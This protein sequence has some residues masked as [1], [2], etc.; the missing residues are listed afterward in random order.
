M[1]RTTKEVGE[2]IRDDAAVAAHVGVELDD[3]YETG[4]V[5]VSNALC[6]TI[7]F[8]KVLSLDVAAL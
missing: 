1:A 3:K 7:Y 4:N 2:T 5:P 6:I 8:P